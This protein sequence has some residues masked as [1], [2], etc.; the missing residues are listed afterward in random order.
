MVDSAEQAEALVRAVRYPPNGIRGMGAAIARAS[1][2]S[3]IPDYVQHASD[4][5]CLLVQVETRAAMADLERIAAV[6][7]LDGIFIGP[8]DLAADLGFPGNFHAPEVQS[9]IE[10]GIATILGAG[11][12]AGI[13]TFDPALNRR[14]IELGAIFVAV[15]ADVTEFSA[16][17]TNLRRKY[18]PAGDE[19]APAV[20]GY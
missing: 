12:P 9:V 20:R 4:D 17:L 6:E 15:G 13:L 14:Y 16:A 2:F 5:I 1:R 3:T 10:A 11:K 18:S 8:A 7:G 19:A